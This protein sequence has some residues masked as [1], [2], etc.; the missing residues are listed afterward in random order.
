MGPILGTEMN[1]QHCQHDDDAA[2]KTLHAGN[3]SEGELP[4]V[5]EEGTER[6]STAESRRCGND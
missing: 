1:A 5:A 4:E 2:Q 6:A 3:Y